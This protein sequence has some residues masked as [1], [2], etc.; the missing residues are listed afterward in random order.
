MVWFPAWAPV[1]RQP[2]AHQGRWA[3]RPSTGQGAQ[4][5]RLSLHPKDKSDLTLG[6]RLQ[7]LSVL[8][9]DRSPITAAE[10]AHQDRD[11][12]AKDMTDLH[13]YGG[14]FTTPWTKVHDGTG[15]FDTT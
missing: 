4:Q 13:P 7:R 14:T 12:S 3:A 5:V 9:D 6:G 1:V 2:P 8:G 10:L 15:T 11:P